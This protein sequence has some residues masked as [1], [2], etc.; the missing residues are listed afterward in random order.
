MNFTK[1]NDIIITICDGAIQTV[2]APDD[3][4]VIVRDYDEAAKCRAMN[5][6]PDN[7]VI[8][9]DDAGDEYVEANWKVVNTIEDEDGTG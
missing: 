3:C 9:K 7:A 4:R 8:K 1:M 6:E 2:E 5:R